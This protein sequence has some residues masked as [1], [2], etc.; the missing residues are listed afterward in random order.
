MPVVLVL[1][2]QHVSQSTNGFIKT[3]SGPTPRISE[4]VGLECGLRIY[5]SSKF[6]GAADAAGLDITL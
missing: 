4:S 2:L 5:I 3:G 1:K 6:P